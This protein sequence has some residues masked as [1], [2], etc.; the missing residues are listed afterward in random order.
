MY[1]QYFGL[2]EAP[3]SI[4]PDPRYLYMSDQHRE[5]LAHLVY[6]VNN[7]NG[8]ILLTGEVGTGKT[9]VCRCLLDQM[10]ENCDVAF[11]LN[12]KVTAGE[13]LATVCDELGIPYPD[14]NASVKLFVDRIN[15]FLL[16]ANSKGRRTIL[17]IEEAQNLCLDVLEQVRLLT[18]LETNHRKL[19]QIIMVG[20]PELREMLY[21]PELLQLS[22]R[23][24]ARYHLGPL[25]ESEVAAYVAHRLEIAG[26]GKRL[27]LPKTIK[28]LNRL[29]GG[30]PRLINIIC[31][32]A[33]LG[34]YVQEKEAVDP[35]TLVSAALEVSGK[36][37]KRKQHSRLLRW[38]LPG[39]IIAGFIG[40]LA[41]GLHHEA[42]QSILSALDRKL[43]TTMTALLPAQER[44]PVAHL[45]GKMTSAQF[46]EKN[47]SCIPTSQGRPCVYEDL[48]MT[49][50]LNKISMLRLIGNQDREYNA[51]PKESAHWEPNAVDNAAEK[52]QGIYGIIEQ[53]TM[54]RKDRS[55]EAYRGDTR[56][57]G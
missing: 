57:G 52:E 13:L 23:I 43:G 37:S 41:A 28:K 22:Q 6:G 27:F 54:P 36:K 50:Y 21:R 5:A 15:A 18:N 56:K 51:D 17:I 30:I 7:D 11:I 20:Q 8:F 31:D 24:T 32:R 4:A 53:Q 49:L 48:D 55:Q 10:P 9:T 14:E 29:S 45:P 46:Q 25:S 40:G 3:F 35:S 47:M 39:F 34:A 42:G 44:N 16:D 2:K 38:V 33:L 19:L 26:G 12:P 1:V